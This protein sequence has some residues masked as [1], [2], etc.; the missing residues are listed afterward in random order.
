MRR[1]TLVAWYELV[2]NGKKRRDS[3]DFFML[4]PRRITFDQPLASE[5]KDDQVS[6]VDSPV[7]EFFRFESHPKHYSDSLGGNSIQHR[8]H[9]DA[10]VHHPRR[11]EHGVPKVD[12]LV[13]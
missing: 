8:L 11:S 3:E 9:S 4:S 1:G 5:A 6:P 12:P 7:S 10:S 13:R 2:R